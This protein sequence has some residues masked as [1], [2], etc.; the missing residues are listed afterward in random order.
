MIETAFMAQVVMSDERLYSDDCGNVGASCNYKH[1]YAHKYHYKYKSLRD[2]GRAAVY[3]DQVRA[4]RS[5]KYSSHYMSTCIA[6]H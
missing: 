1:E 6:M 2:Y 5:C 3:G 4:C